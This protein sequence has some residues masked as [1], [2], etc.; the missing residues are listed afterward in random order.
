MTT[1]L[2]RGSVICPHSES[3][4]GDV[5]G[6]RAEMRRGHQPRDPSTRQ[7]SSWRLY[8]RYEPFLTELLEGDRPTIPTLCLPPVGN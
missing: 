5:T 4:S 6:P 2:A 1:Y 7:T 8:T 3:G